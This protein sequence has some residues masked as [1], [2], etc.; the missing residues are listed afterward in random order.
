MPLI[1]HRFFKKKYHSQLCGSVRNVWCFYWSFYDFVLNIIIS[2]WTENTNTFFKQVLM[3]FYLF[4]FLC[5]WKVIYKERCSARCGPGRQKQKVRCVKTSATSYEITDEKYC[6]HLP[7]THNEVVPCEGKCL[8]THWGYDT[9]SVVSHSGSLA[10]F[11]SICTIMA[12]KL[13]NLL[14][15]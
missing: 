2:R 10:L 14:C 13:R 8:R 6:N 11:H 15:N 1:F 3:S 12:V 7:K 9:W 5:S 4:S